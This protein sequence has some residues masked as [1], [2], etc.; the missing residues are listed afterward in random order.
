MLLE[1]QDKFKEIDRSSLWTVRASHQLGCA[2]GIW[3]IRWTDDPN[4]HDGPG[5]F[6]ITAQSVRR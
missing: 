2:R 1:Q 4:R 5:S 6:L 3:I